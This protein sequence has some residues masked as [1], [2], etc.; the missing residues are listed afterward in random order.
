MISKM[1]LMGLNDQVNSRKKSNVAT[2]FI[3]YITAVSLLA[4]FDLILS[5]VRESSVS[6]YALSVIFDL[7]LSALGLTFCSDL[8]KDKDPDSITCF[9]A[10]MIFLWLC[11]TVLK[12]VLTL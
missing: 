8:I 11:I 2:Y 3:T 7:T 5:F 9:L 1:S 4:A 12:T 10:Y 6:A